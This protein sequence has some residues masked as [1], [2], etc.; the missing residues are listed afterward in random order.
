MTEFS[1]Q[2]MADRLAIRDLI[3]HY[4]YYAD[5]AD[6]QAQAALFTEDTDYV[7]Y[8]DA[9]SATPT[10]TVKGRANLVPVFE[11]LT[12]YQAKMHFNGQNSVW[13]DSTERARGY[14]YCIAHHLSVEEGV[15]KRMVA[16]MRYEDVFVK[17]NG[18]W[19]FAE[20]KLLVDWVE[21]R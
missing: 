21:N 3:D 13:F 1:L 12:H 9:K 18:K 11:A 2:E 10:Q 4:A 5:Q 7:V 6:P 17:Q 16:A 8:M 14:S 19:L 20:R 15:Q